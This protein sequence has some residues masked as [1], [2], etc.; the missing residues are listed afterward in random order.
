MP[1][2]SVLKHSAA[3]C[4]AR[5]KSTQNRCLNPAAFGCRTCRLHGARKPSSIK[6]GPNHPNYRHGLETLSAKHQRSVKLAELRTIETELLNKGLI[7]GARTAGRKPTG[8]QMKGD[9]IAPPNFGSLCDNV[10]QQ[11]FPNWLQ[12]HHS[13]LR[14]WTAKVSSLK[15]V[16]QY[17]ATALKLN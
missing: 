1:L 9:C 15:W 16:W 5:A 7:A 2:P 3:Q 4:T 6:A 12:W 13:G 11:H 14:G 17:V 10:L 8:G